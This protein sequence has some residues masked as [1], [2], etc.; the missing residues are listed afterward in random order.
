MIALIVEFRLRPGAQ[1]SFDRLMRTTIAH[2]EAK[3]RDT[4]LYVCHQIVGERGVRILYELYRSQN[5]FAFHESQDYIA[6]FLVKRAQYL[7]MPPVVTWCR[8][9]LGTKDLG[10]NKARILPKSS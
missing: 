10:A 6:S 1:A 2:V 7:R 3:E 4:L 5:A 9:V 8:P